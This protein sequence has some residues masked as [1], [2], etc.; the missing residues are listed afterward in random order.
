MTARDDT[1]TEPEK[2]LLRL[3][4]QIA[5]SREGAADNTPEAVY[6][7]EILKSCGPDDRLEEMLLAQIAVTHEAALH[8]LA[9]ASSPR[10]DINEKTE[11]LAA[12]LKFSRLMTDH[13][14]TLQ[15]CRK[16]AKSS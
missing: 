1:E 9:Q 3:L 14:R 13:A 12:S 5:L 8:Y 4:R 15:K 7:A 6:M 10:T 16:P 11:G 2:P